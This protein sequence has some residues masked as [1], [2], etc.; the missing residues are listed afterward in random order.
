MCV[1]EAKATVLGS[2]PANFQMSKPKAGECFVEKIVGVEDSDD[3]R[4]CKVRWQGCPGQDS[5]ERE[6]NV[7]GARAAIEESWLTLGEPMPESEVFRKKKDEK[8][9]L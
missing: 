2:K 6:V 8:K 5:W 4:K 1:N 7:A 9:R 3:S